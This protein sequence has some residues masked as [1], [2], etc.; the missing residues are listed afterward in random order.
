MPRHIT[1]ILVLCA[2]ALQ[3]VFGAF[4]GTATICLGG[5]HETAAAEVANEA[6]ADD[7][8]PCAHGCDHAATP[9]PLPVEDHDDP[10]DCTDLDLLVIELLS[11]PRDQSDLEMTA[12]PVPL[13]LVVALATP[14]TALPERHV[15]PRSLVDHP[16]GSAQLAAVRATRLLI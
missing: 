9:I 6:E 3:G 14:G 4:P 7:A 1:A 15:P 10:C 11:T 16:P 5:G 2:I 8:G 12:P 13:D